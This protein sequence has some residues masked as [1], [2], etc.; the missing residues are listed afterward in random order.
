MALHAEKV[1]DPWVREYES[2]SYDMFMAVWESS[3]WVHRAISLHE[4]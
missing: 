4:R 3:S 2:L 1:A